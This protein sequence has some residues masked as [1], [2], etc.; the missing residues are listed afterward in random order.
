VR[1]RAT[2]PS[3]M[4]AGLPSGIPP[5]LGPD[6]APAPAATKPLRKSAAKTGDSSKSNPNIVVSSV[7][8]RAPDESS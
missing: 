8:P 2:I 6:G 5:A 4:P 3:G 1:I 7:P